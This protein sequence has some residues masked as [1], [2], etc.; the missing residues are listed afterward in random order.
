M[1]NPTGLPSDDG[2][3]DITIPPTIEPQG[4]WVEIDENSFEGRRDT[5]WFHTAITCALV[6]MLLIWAGTPG[7]APSMAARTGVANL[8]LHFG[9]WITGFLAI[10]AAIDA[11]RLRRDEQE[12]FGGGYD[13]RSDVIGRSVMLLG[14]IAAFALLANTALVVAALL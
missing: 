10:D 11:W 4:G 6:G 14:L 8:I 2:D 1:P 7:E 9:A 3:L 12:Q 13:A 5:A